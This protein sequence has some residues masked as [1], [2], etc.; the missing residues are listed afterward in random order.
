M[1]PPDPDYILRGFDGPV[2][3]LAFLPNSWDHRYDGTYL[4]GD[5]GFAPA[6][7]LR[8]GDK[9][10][11]A[12]ST[13]EQ[14]HVAVV[15]LEGG[16]TVTTLKPQHS[17]GMVMDMKPGGEDL[18][19]AGYE[20]G[21]IVVWDVRFPHHEKNSAQLHQEAVS[22]F[23]Y[24]QRTQRGVSASVD[25]SL[26]SW[27]GAELKQTATANIKGGAACVRARP[28]GKLFAVGGC[29]SRIHVFSGR[30]KLLLLAVVRAHTQSVQSLAFND[31]DQT[32][33]AGSRDKT[34]SMWSIYKD[35]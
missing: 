10:M 18:I 25:G 14:S 16:E 32:F 2:T 21:S 35:T 15:A 19:M 26:I 33:A 20:D 22:S 34:V 9:L 31:C 11:L 8:L 6:A 4:C 24:C 27:G 17:V 5:L 28:D 13:S 30:P 29:D 7:V 3:S 1:E 23:D 12:A